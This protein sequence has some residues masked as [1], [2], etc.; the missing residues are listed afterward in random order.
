MI[1]VIRCETIYKECVLLKRLKSNFD[2]GFQTYQREIIRCH[3]EIKRLKYLIDRVKDNVMVY[4]RIKHSCSLQIGRI[5]EYERRVEQS[6][7]RP[8]K[9][10]RFV[11]MAC[12]P[13]I[14]DTP[15]LTQHLTLEKNKKDLIKLLTGETL[16]NGRVLPKRLKSNVDIGVQI[17]QKEISQ[18]HSIKK[19]CQRLK[20]LIDSVKDNVMIRI[21][22]KHSCSLQKKRLAQYIGRIQ[23]YERRFEQSVYRPV[24]FLRFVKMDSLPQKSDTPH[25]T[26]HYLLNLSQEINMKDLVELLTGIQIRKSTER[27]IQAENELQFNLMPSPLLQKSFSVTGINGSDHISRV[28][29]NRVWVS[30]RNNLILTDTIR[31]DILYTLKDSVDSDRAKHTMNREG[32]LIYIN[33]DEVVQLFSNAK[34]TTTPLKNTDCRLMPQCLY[35][36]PSTGDILVGVRMIEINGNVPKNCD[37]TYF[38]TGM[39]MRYISTW[40]H[41]QTIPDK[42]TPFLQSSP[43]FFLTVNHNG[44]IVMPA[45]YRDLHES[46]YKKIKNDIIGHIIQRIQNEF[47]LNVL[48]IHPC[49][50]TENDNGD[51]VVSDLDAVKVTSREGVHRFSYTGPPSKP[52]Q[53]FF[54]PHGI[55]TDS[56]SHILVCDEYTGTVHMLSKDGKFLKYLLCGNSQG[57]DGLCS[58]NYDINTHSLWVG[59]VRNNKVCVFRHM[60]R[61]H[62]LAGKSDLSFIYCNTINYF[63]T[64]F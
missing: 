11:K 41:T 7:Y 19:R 33:K 2:T 43:S 21:R 58:L 31:G 57:I 44:D 1:H 25:L 3:S 56:L 28:T 64:L 10:L 30:D 37:F 4:R 36:S 62:T 20:Y 15:R 63:N 39:V 60:T 14:S 16:Y 22:I 48:Y 6:V 38:F 51:V 49:Y 13:Q 61:D 23:K 9:F 18:Y 24:K 26:E 45:S 8:V 46:V 17:C 32:E 47:T 53:G 5:Q 55:C 40:Q 50:I 29:S 52:R 27:T 12:L 59:S 54:R 42:I 34:E 35:C